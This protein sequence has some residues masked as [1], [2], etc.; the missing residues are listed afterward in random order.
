MRSDEGVKSLHMSDKKKNNSLT[1][2]L[3]ENFD[4]GPN[5]IPKQVQLKV[6]DFNS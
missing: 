2:L 4:F 3:S 1:N 5:V 6:S